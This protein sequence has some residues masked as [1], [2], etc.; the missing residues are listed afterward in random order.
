MA[1]APHDLSAQ[2]M[3]EL[4]ILR[5]GLEDAAEQ[6]LAAIE[7]A[8]ERT[9]RIRDPQTRV[10]LDLLLFTAMEACAFQ[11][12]AGQRLSNVARLLAGAALPA[13]PLLE[14]PQRPGMGLNQDAADAVFGRSN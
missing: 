2:I 1:D 4:A 13:D 14:G 5:G 6:I 10:D 3:D 9:G 7:K 12:L 11:D 8:M